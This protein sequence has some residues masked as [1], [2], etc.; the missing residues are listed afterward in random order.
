MHLAAPVVKDAELQRRRLGALR[1]R[2]LAASGSHAP[3]S[4]G[5]GYALTR[6]LCF[7]ESHMDDCSG[8]RVS[9]GDFGSSG[10]VVGCMHSAVGQWA[11]ACMPDDVSSSL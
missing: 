4:G 10:N 9:T 2:L 1:A 5:A 8:W 3:Q 6:V 11:C 7:M